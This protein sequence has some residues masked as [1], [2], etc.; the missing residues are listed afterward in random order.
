MYLKCYLQGTCGNYLLL[1]LVKARE[2]E[3]RKVSE[4]ATGTVEREV[5][6]YKGWYLKYRNNDWKGERAGRHD[7]MKE[8]RYTVPTGN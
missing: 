7:G 4:E 2:K 3:R 1:G 6:T 5:H 8:C